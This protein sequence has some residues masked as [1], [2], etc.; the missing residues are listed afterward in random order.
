[1]FRG[2]DKPTKQRAEPFVSNGL[3]QTQNQKL[4]NMS[5]SA[6]SYME[7]VWANEKKKL[8]AQKRAEKKA[9]KLK[10]AN[11]Q[12]AVAI[13]KNA[14][15]PIKAIANIGQAAT[16]KAIKSNYRESILSLD[17]K[18]LD[19]PMQ[20]SQY[21]KQ[22]FI[23]YL[24]EE[25]RY[26]LRP[27][28][29]KKSPNLCYYVRGFVVNHLIRWH[30]HFQL[31][32]ET[33][34]LAL[35]V[36]DKFISTRVT[37][38][39]EMQIIC[40]T[41]LFIASKFEEVKVIRLDRYLRNCSDYITPDKVLVLEGHIMK[42]L[43]F[44]LTLVCPHDFLKRIF[45]VTNTDIAKYTVACYLLEAFL[46]HDESAS[47]LSSQKAIAAYFLTAEL[48]KVTFDKEKI[49]KYIQYDEEEVKKIIQITA[50]IMYNI[51]G[52]N[53]NSLKEKYSD[54]SWVEAKLKAQF[55]TTRNA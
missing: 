43:D 55:L 23:H 20:V 29:L 26:V 3:S 48:L 1:M 12:P 33:L 41:S 4:N 8:A 14:S 34:F 53:F 54:N 35:Y 39:I 40:V 51:D 21:C 52:N 15:K 42:A 5:T 37:K 44:R 16:Q 50:K 30:H 46:F 24:R 6:A 49:R 11:A 32:Q 17:Q 10:N 22:I 28:W 38:R 18:F 13:Q 9:L 2:E 31:R 47:F 25:K 45:Y 27:N 7:G 19:D 36:M